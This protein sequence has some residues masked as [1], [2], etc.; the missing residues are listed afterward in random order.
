MQATMNFLPRTNSYPDRRGSEGGGSRR[1]SR[2]MLN[3]TGAPAV[4]TGAADEQGHTATTNGVVDRVADRVADGAGL[5]AEDF[6]RLQVE[7]HGYKEGMYEAEQKV[8][9]L[10]AELERQREGVRGVGEGTIEGLFSRMPWGRD[11]RAVEQENAQLKAAVKKIMEESEREISALRKSLQESTMARK[12]LADELLRAKQAIGDET[13]LS[14]QVARLQ[15][16]VEE[17]QG[18]CRAADER[19]EEVAVELAA[20]RSIKEP[21]G[22]ADSLRRVGSTEEETRPADTSNEVDFYRLEAAMWREKCARKTQAVKEEQEAREKEGREAQARVEAMQKHV[23]GLK[24]ELVSATTATE[25]LRKLWLSREEEVHVLNSRLASAEETATMQMLGREQA[26]AQGQAAD[27]EAE[28]WRV[29]CRQAG[30][31][32]DKLAREVAEWRQLAEKRKVMVDDLSKQLQTS[33]SRALELQQD[34]DQ[35]HRAAI[36]ELTNQIAELAAVAEAAKKDLLEKLKTARAEERAKDKEVGRLTELVDTLQAEKAHLE[37]STSRQEE[38]ITKLECVLLETQTQ[39]A[40]QLA[41]KDE[42]VVSVTAIARDQQANAL[43][44]Q[45]HAEELQQQLS[46]TTAAMQLAEKKHQSMVKDLKRELKAYRQKEGKSDHL[47]VD[48]Q[49]R[50]SL[51]SLENPKSLS[52]RRFESET[53]IASTGS[54]QA[55]SG[56]IIPEVIYETTERV[57]QLEEDKARLITK[58]TQMQCKNLLLRE[59]VRFLEQANELLSRDV[60]DKAGL[61]EA[62]IMDT[63]AGAVVGRRTA[64]HS[65]SPKVERVETSDRRSSLMDRLRGP[66]QGTGGDREMQ[67][68]LQSMLEETLTKNIEL[69]KNIEL[70]SRENELLRQRFVGKLPEASSGG[71]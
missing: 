55:G 43:A 63:K 11:Q 42:E 60:T 68:R 53:S 3:F 22:S 41:A 59:R 1:G 16:E 30:E 51:D 23:E 34:T 36:S 58:V 38:K 57:R 54:G 19:T 31:Q 52:L 66:A 49:R 71:C 2:D 6:Q 10:Q 65:L 44:A 20:L 13:S 67:R 35:R 50:P 33:E 5:T 37:A 14:G 25:Q 7:L 29:E 21:R 62:F 45:A 61:I 48:V 27:R 69:Q 8:K 39:M 26:E 24:A 28:R 17:W 47:E 40:A 46:D 18:K 64:E 56:P 15:R 9:K 4:A 70:L 32:R 12:N